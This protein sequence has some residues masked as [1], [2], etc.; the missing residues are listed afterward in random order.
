MKTKTTIEIFSKKPL[1]EYKDGHIL[2]YDFNKKAYLVTDRQNF[3][4][5]QN[6]KIE[7]LEKKFNAFKENVEK[8]VKTMKENNDSFV[9]NCKEENTKF[10]EKVNSDYEKFLEGYQETNNTVITLIKSLEE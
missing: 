4:S 3:L 6:K 10:T 9:Q 1:N 8:Q 2:I 5:P 7:D